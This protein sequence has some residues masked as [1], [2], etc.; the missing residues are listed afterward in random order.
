MTR[1]KLLTCVFSAFIFEVMKMRMLRGLSLLAALCLA[2]LP[3]LAQSFGDVVFTEVMYDDTAGTDIE[4]V[5]IHNTTAASIDI[6]NWVVGD[7]PSYPGPA[8]EG[9]IT[10]PAATSI[11]AGAYLVLCR[12]AIAEFAGEIL[13]TGAGSWTLGNTGDNLTLYTAATGGTLI[14]GSLTVS[15]PDGAAN[16]AGNSIEKCDVNATWTGDPAAWIESTTVFA[17]V[18]RYRHCTPGAA[19]T[20]CGGGDITPPALTSITVITNTQIDVLFDENVNLTV[21]ETEAN[22]SVNNAVGNPSSAV[23]DVTNNSLVHL[24]FAAMAPNNYTLTVLNVQDIAGNPATNLTGNFTI[25]PPATNNVVITEVMYDDTAGTDVEWIEL[26]NTTGS[27][28]N[29]GG[30]IV[31][32]HNTYPPTSEGALY[33]PAGTT[34]NA[35]QYLVLSTLDIPEFAGELICPDSVGGWGLSNSGDNLAIYTA[36]SG[37]TLIYGSLTVSFPD[38]SAGNTGSSIEVCSADVGQS[39]DV[40]NWYESAAVFATT[41]RYRFCTPGAAPSPCIA[42]VIP[43]VL[44][45]VTVITSSQI[46]AVFNENL[47]E[48]SAETVANYSVDLGIGVP[49]TAV[50]QPDGNTVRLS[51]AASIPA[52]TYTL[53]VNNVTDVAGNP[54]AP[55]SSAQFTI[56]PSAYDFVITEFMPNPNFAGTADS[57]GEWFEIYNHGANAVNMSGWIISDANGSDTLE[58]N[59]TIAAGAYFVFCSN[60]DSATNGGVPENYAYH[61]GTTG[62]GLGLNN[63]GE[64]ITVRDANNVTAVALSY[65]GLPFVAGASAQ[66]SATNLDPSNPT[67][68]C[69]AS[70]AWNGA[71][72]GDLGTPGAANICGAPAVPDTLTICQIRAQNEC[73]V[74]VW[75]DSLLVTYGVVTHNDSCRRNMYVEYNGCAILV[76]GTAAQL[77]MQ[78]STRLALPG[79][80]VRIEGALDFFN[81][82]SEFS[83]FALHAAVVTFISAGH[84]VPAA[85]VVAANTISQ[86]AAACA[87]E[88]NEAR[89]IT[90]QNVTFDTTGGVDTFL[91]NTN[92]LLFNGTDTIQFRVNAC[93]SLVGQ[94][95]PL[96]ALNVTGI[97]A[98]FDS[99]GACWCQDYQLLTG[100][101]AP[102]ETAMCGEPVALTAYRLA[103]TNT[104]QL[105]WSPA[106]ANSCGCYN[107]WYASNSDAAFPAEYTLLTPIPTSA[108]TFDDTPLGGPDT[109]RF[110][111]VTGVPCP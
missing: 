102:F 13:C 105:R 50:L 91:T 110:Y 5:E 79:D 8:G 2:A 11:A 14:D 15:F 67:N 27:T 84:A 87:P 100:Q 89:H 92:F 108:I 39:W 31:T 34:I 90:V 68:W 17:A 53:T 63:T 77:P 58:G 75:N 18:G 83:Q 38:L 64:L 103:G 3:V 33:I 74:P 56:V 61:Y 37:G 25:A 49:S 59:P 20:P 6:S 85:T 26:Y 51:F 88:A 41:G 111:V 22:Y 43:P 101:L 86:N 10:V 55:N 65:N 35:G 47:T 72:N 24:T 23:R 12:V 66:L 96:G 82:V 45:G 16:N 70:T 71:N 32:D 48:V 1:L 93:D 73:G 81:G 19:N 36:L 28:I 99:S 30:W 97:L 4:W 44:T 94:P 104:V 69:T 98:Q 80:S 109:K 57:L 62:W 54:I 42:D 40:V 78:N 21:A 106:V 7:G 95:I 52:N 76:F 9:T 46:D 29:I 60:G 107:V